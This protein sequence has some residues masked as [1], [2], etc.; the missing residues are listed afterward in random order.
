MLDW[1]IG[2]LSVLRALQAQGVAARV[3]YLSDAGVTPYGKLPPD[4]LAARV[5]DRCRLLQS[6]GA[7]RIVVAC[8]AASTVLD[9]VDAPTVGVIQ[10]GI[11]AV[12]DSGL[13]RVAVLGGQRTVDSHLY[14]QGL[15]Q[16]HVIERCAQPLSALVEAG[17]LTGPHVEAAVQ[18]VL[19]PVGEVA[20]IVLACTHYPALA[21]VFR[22]L[23]P[24]A[25]LLDP[26]IAAAAQLAKALDPGAVEVTFA[27]SGDPQAMRA[28]A[29]AAFGVEIPSLRSLP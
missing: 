7:E 3:H 2:G 25:L 12:R 11:Q 17:E 20:G 28:A 1:G 8:N 10:A 19:E 29:L 18:A 22:S 27:T 24:E 6:L 16:V 26:G 15:P 13:Q 21:P 9:R 23:R 5:E 4:Q 14:A